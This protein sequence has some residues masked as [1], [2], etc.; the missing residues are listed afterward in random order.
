MSL[1]FDDF[2][3]H[4]S[5]SLPLLQ[6]VLVMKPTSLMWVTE[7]NNTSQNTKKKPATNKP[8]K[9]TKTPRYPNAGLALANL[10]LNGMLVV[11]SITFQRII[12]KWHDLLLNV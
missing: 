2:M 3:W 10:T 7:K 12:V 4:T 8:D 11:V 6:N 5:C 1:Q 9:Q